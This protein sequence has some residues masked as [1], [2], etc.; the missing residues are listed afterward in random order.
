MITL[1]PA[2]ER[3]HTRSGGLDSYHTFSFCSYHDPC[4]I[5]F[6]DLL[7][8]NEDCVQPSY[9]FPVNA[10]QDVE[11]ISYVLTGI[12]MYEDS[13]GTHS[14]IR[15][16][17]MG[18]MSAGTGI[19]HSQFNVS[20][21]E[22]AH[23][24]QI[25]LVPEQ[26]G[27]PPFYEQKTFPKEERRSVLRLVA[28]RDGRDRSLTIHQDAVLYLTALDARRQVILDISRNRHAW[29]QVMRGEV[30]LNGTPLKAGDGAAVREEERLAIAAINT[31][32]VLLL[33]LA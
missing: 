7:V 23:L 15:A 21:T 31:A 1:R 6:R 33:D 17:D 2:D 16:G 9:G 5:G 25:W 26:E 12:L 13:L 8:L 30:M 19:A 3:A 20:A 11:I 14:T 10:H 32:E 18:R 29:V 24:L 4:Y 28:S 22:L 27:L